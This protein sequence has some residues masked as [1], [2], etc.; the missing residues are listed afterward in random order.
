MKW[1]QGHPNSSKTV[2][3]SEEANLDA[4]MD[5]LMKKEHLGIEDKMDVL[6]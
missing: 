5:L 4:R 2:F 3:I 1:R 6:S